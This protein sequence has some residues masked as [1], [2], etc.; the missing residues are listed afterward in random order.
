VRYASTHAR[1]PFFAI[2]GI[3]ASNI[4]AVRA[5]G[6]ERVAVVRAIVDAVDPEAAAR[7]LTEEEVRVGAT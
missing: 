7:A 4:A 5:A 1:V 6:A 3:D 2:G